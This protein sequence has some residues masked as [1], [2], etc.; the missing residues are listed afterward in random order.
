[1]LLLPEPEEE[2]GEVEQLEIALPPGT[3][4]SAWRLPKLALLEK[5]GSQEIDGQLIAE[6]G[7]RLERALA[8]HGVETRLTGMVAGPT[9]TRYEL[10]LAP[11]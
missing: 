6:D 1:M 11:G 8:E 4:R 10:E 2:P 5:A 3:R 7:R 9:V